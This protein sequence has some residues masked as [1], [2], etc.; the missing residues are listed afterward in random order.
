[1]EDYEVM[2]KYIYMYYIHVV[3][4]AMPVSFDQNCLHIT[5]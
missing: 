2:N 3:K 4:D 1:M 5:F